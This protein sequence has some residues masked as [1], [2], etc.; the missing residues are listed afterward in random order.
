MRGDT[1]LIFDFIKALAAYENLLDSVKATEDGLERSLFDD[2]AAEVIF[3][4]CDEQAV[5]FA[6]YYQ[7]YSTFAGST[8][9]Y[10]E[11][12]F[13]QAAFR[14]KGIG[15]QLLQQ[16]AKVAV[17]R[18]AGRFEWSCL[19]WNESSIAFYRRMG[20]APVL[21]WTVF[22][23]TGSKLQALADGDS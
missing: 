3:A 17:E 22:R 13:V 19:N 20:A 8:G 14:G 2:G 4:L 23:I 9:I 12:L 1:A 5:G 10:L 11:D 7:N 21:D 16:V 18:H 6:L 15:K